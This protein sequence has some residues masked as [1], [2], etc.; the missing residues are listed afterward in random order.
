MLEL[1]QDQIDQLRQT[2]HEAFVGRV[3]DELAAKYPDMKADGRL[4]ARLLAAH[5]AALALGLQS[6]EARTQF[7]YQESF[8]PSFYQQPAIVAWLTKEGAHP[9]RRWK[10]FVAYVTAKMEAM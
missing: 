10:D 4:T 5:R 8:A 9:E 6:P 7:L 3:R 1:T 2:E